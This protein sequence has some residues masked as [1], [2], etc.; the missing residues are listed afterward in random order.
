MRIL[1]SF[2]LVK[3]TGTV[4]G[5]IGGS[6]LFS[7]IIVGFTLGCSLIGD[8]FGGVDGGGV[9]IDGV[10]PF[11]REFNANRFVSL[12]LF[13]NITEDTHSDISFAPNELEKVCV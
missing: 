7:L 1:S 11:V 12:I 6:S 4:I 3:V 9:R 13:K 8:V 2:E 5:L 10:D